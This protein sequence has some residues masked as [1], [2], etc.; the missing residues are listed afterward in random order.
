MKTKK[1]FKFPYSDW[2]QKANR[3]LLLNAY[4]VWASR[5]IDIISPRNLIILL[6]V[7]ACTAII[8]YFSFYGLQSFN[9]LLF[10]GFGFIWI[11]FL[12][13]FF[14]ATTWFLFLFP[15]PF[16]ENYPKFEEAISISKALLS[17]T[18]AKD[19]LKLNLLV[20][21]KTSIVLVLFCP[22]I[23]TIS[24]FY[25]QFSKDKPY[26]QLNENILYMGCYLVEYY[27]RGIP[28]KFEENS[29]LPKEMSIYEDEKFVTNLLNLK[30]D[31]GDEEDEKYNELLR[32]GYQTALTDFGPGI[33]KKYRVLTTNLSLIT[34]KS[35]Y[36][37]FSYIILLFS[38]IISFSMLSFHKTISLVSGSNAL[39][40]MFFY[41]ISFVIPL[42]FLVLPE[43]P[44][45]IQVALFIS[46]CIFFISFIHFQFKKKRISFYL[47]YNILPLLIPSAA[48][49]LSP[50]VFQQEITDSSA[51]LAATALLNLLFCLGAYFLHWK[52]LNAVLFTPRLAT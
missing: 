34:F 32:Y 1:N 44:F 29:R 6:A 50:I 4:P 31:E 39:L 17:V 40:R 16:R 38:T 21:L 52:T 5:I 13:G 2:H 24:H 46:L 8:I 30:G 10:I 25:D 36:D 43:S 48:V 26:L 28:F 35:L 23:L 51:I 19:D 15:L 37:N 49:L 18:S 20:F 9:G 14:L 45:A 27:D 12:S 47:A 42:L 7:Y 22:V 41:S 3:K 33:L 11:L